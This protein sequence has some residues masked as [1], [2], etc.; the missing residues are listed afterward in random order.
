MK[1][2]KHFI[3]LSSSIL[4][5]SCGVNTVNSKSDIPT[6][7]IKTESLRPN[8]DKTEENIGIISNQNQSLKDKIKDEGDIIDAQKVD[9]SSSIQQAGNIKKQVSSKKAVTIK[10]ATDLVDELKKIEARNLF[11]EKENNAL[12]KLSQ[13]QKE[14]IS[15]TS[16][17]VTELSRKISANENELLTLRSQNSDLAKIISSRDKDVQSLQT[18]NQKLTVSSA[19]AGVYKH[20]II[21]IVAAFVAWTIIK[22]VLMI[23][24]PTSRFRL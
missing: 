6:A 8:I 10:Q 21:G 4:L 7:P 2:I 5:A 11:L 1:M 14:T 19:S 16:S 18:D 3:I 12:A 13:S 9:I 15:T 20:W 24:F 22:N 17:V 23:Y